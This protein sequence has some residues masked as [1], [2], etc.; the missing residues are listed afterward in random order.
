MAIERV[1]IFV[2]HFEVR[3]VRAV[4]IAPIPVHDFVYLRLTD[5]DGAIGWGEAYR[6]PGVA[7]VLRDLAPVV[8]GRDPR[9]ARRLHA[10][11][12]LAAEH[13][14]ASSAYAIAIDDLRGRLLGVPVHRLYGGA[15]RD[16]VRA[17]GASTGYIEGR[18]PADTWQIGRA[19]V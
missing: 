1:E 13:T 9:D 4:S 19:H 12:L 6:I 3:P 15:V 18:D 16:R 17:Y 11:V 2:V 8:L 5:S 14:W 10:D 7:E